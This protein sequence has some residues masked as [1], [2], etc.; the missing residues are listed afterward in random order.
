MNND[1]KGLI[2]IVKGI[3]TNLVA[4]FSPRLF[5][6]LTHETGRGEEATPS[7][8]LV[9]YC[10]QVINEYAEMMAMD[11]IN[12][13]QWI[14]GRTV[15]EYGPGDF[16]GVPLILLAKGAKKIFCLDRFPLKDDSK[17]A[18]LYQ[19]M[20][21]VWFE[22][23]FSKHWHDLL[24]RDIQYIAAPDGIGALP[25]KV[26]L[27]VSRAVLEHCNNLQ[28]TFAHMDQHLKPGGFMIHKVDLT[29]HS[30]HYRHEFEF[31]CYTRCQWKAM[32]CFKGYPN[33]FRRNTY[34]ELI[35][36]HRFHLIHSQSVYGFS[37]TELSRFRHDLFTDFKNLDEKDLLCSDLFFIAQKPC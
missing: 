7:D 6:S 21:N 14:R 11:D 27:I 9:A 18:N 4:G 12:L 22:K 15:L 19:N 3:A 33:R 1:L 2:R 35:R 26:D 28:E 37:K 29:S 20:I 16:L 23:D 32:T 36:K 34:L 31:L 5:M 17:Y 13:D 24:S 8:K 25:E 10:E 30:E